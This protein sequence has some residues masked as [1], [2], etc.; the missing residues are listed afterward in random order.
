MKKTSFSAAGSGF[1]NTLIWTNPLKPRSGFLRKS[2]VNKTS[3]RLTAR[4]GVIFYLKDLS[5]ISASS[6]VKLPGVL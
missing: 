3:P 4:R 2:K 1:I 6:F 5:A